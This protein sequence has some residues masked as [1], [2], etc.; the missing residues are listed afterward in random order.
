MLDFKRWIE[1]GQCVCIVRQLYGN[2][3]DRLLHIRQPQLE[4]SITRV[5][6]VQFLPAVFKQP[7]DA[8]QTGQKTLLK[9]LAST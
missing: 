9:E 1:G 2:T 5:R 3:L 6:K 8:K 7:L 4:V